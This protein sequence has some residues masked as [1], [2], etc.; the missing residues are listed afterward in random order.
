MTSPASLRVVSATSA[1]PQPA[2]AAHVHAVVAAAPTPSMSQ[3]KQLARLLMPE[4]LAQA[5]PL[6]FNQVTREAA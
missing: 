4:L 1:H 2:Y 6:P 3:A 5:A